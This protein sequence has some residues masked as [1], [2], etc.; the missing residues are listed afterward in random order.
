MNRFIFVIVGLAF[1]LLSCSSARVVSRASELPYTYSRLKL[2]DIDEMND[3]VLKRVKAYQK[4]K[5]QIKRGCD[6]TV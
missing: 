5:N 4:S 3:I 2:L 1:F 6:L